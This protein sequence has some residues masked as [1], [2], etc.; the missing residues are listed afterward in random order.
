[1]SKKKAGLPDVLSAATR[2]RNAGGAAASVAKPEPEPES[3]D[4]VVSA[5]N[6]RKTDW[7]LLRKVAEARVDKNDGKGRRSVSAVLQALIEENRKALEA[8]IQK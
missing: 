6:L 3:D 8:E 7:K 5:I 2:L 1:M 4:F